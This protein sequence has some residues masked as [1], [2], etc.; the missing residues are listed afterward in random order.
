MPSL[1]AKIH[2][3]LH[4]LTTLYFNSSH[5]PG[6]HW[7]PHTPGVFVLKVQTTNP[8]LLKRL[9]GDEILEFVFFISF[10]ADFSAH[11]I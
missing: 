7:L 6:L 5:P 4:I 3:F 1:L 9:T 11:M 10:L 8:D 2:P